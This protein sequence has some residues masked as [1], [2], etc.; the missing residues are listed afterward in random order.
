MIKVLLLDNRD[1][2]TY[3][4][5]GLLRNNGKVKFNITTSETIRREPVMHYDKIL[6]SP[7][8]GIPAE[9]ETI[10]ELLESYGDKK[11]IL[12]IC[13]GMQAIALHFGGS[14]YNLDKPMHG[15]V[16]KIK[17]I[18]PGQK[19]FNGI[20]GQFEAGL[21]HSW[22]VKKDDLPGDLL[23]TALSYD[24]IIMGLKHRHLDICG[25]QFHPESIMTL[26]GQKML[27]NWLEK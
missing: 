22:A 5:A 12:G 9:H 15:Q 25:V 16:K 6:I 2:F 7:G 24:G 17:I 3:N 11:S 4:L 14:L 8:P 23:I 20:P 27:D 18:I 13:L 26:L 10:W 21:Y 19:L 1:S